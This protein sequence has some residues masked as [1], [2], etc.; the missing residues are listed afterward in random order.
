MGDKGLG[1]GPGDVVM[2]QM[3]LKVGEDSAALVSL[4]GS[5]LGSSAQF[6]S[7]V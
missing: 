1:L 2:T 6:F 3:E 5:F 7:V 4:I